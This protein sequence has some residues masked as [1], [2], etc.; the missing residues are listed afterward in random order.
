MTPR[1]VTSTDPARE[2]LEYCPE[3]AATSILDDLRRTDYSRLDR[4]DQAYLDYTGGGM[5][6]DS[7]VRAHA[8]LL[9]GHVLGNP[10]SVSLSSSESTTLVERARRAVLD[11]FGASGEYTAIFTLN[12]SNAL[13]LVGESFPFVQ[14]S[15]FLLAFDN[16]NS[17]NGIREFARAKGAT[18]DYAPLT[19]PDLRLDPAKLDALL[20]TIDRRVPNLF[21]FPAQS[22]FSGVKHP[23]DL[24]EQARRAGWYV[25]LDAAAFVPTNRLDL[26]VVTPDFVT[27][28]FY[29]MFGY[30]TGVGCLLVR[31]QALP[32]LRR[33]W[34][35]GGTVNFATVQGRAHILSP[36]E[37]GFEDGTLNYLSIPAVDIGLRHI[38]RIGIDTIH[39]RVQALGGWLLHKL[40]DLRHANG[41]HMVRIYGPATMKARGA[42]LTMNFYDPDGHLV[43]YR[44]VEELASERRLSL[45]T[46]CFCNPGAGEA[47]EQLTEADMRAAMDGGP[48]MNL[49]KFVQLM[50]GRGGKAAGAIRVSFGLASNVNDAA[51]FLAFAEELRDQTRLTLGAVSFDIE[52][53]RII[54]DGS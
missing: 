20:A 26:K 30:P 18:F 15:R 50:Q 36:G 24:V 12:A 17:V 39:T 5:Y 10:H 28:S 21:A 9:T 46:G 41:R 34:F 11:Y 31:N 14:G 38:E 48:D 29:K 33:P 45:R 51:R 49:A 32:L 54:R 1:T 53:C 23:L 16:H 8:E 22:N 3:Y 40:L 43:D 2:L 35:A 6:A 13:K 42:T 37:A 47:A 44:R 25:L 4:D 27:V 19:L 52:S 7:Q